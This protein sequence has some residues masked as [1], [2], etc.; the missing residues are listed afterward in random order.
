MLDNYGYNHTLRTFNT[1]CCSTVTIVTRRSV[2]VTLY[3]PCPSLLIFCLY[4]FLG[5]P[6]NGFP[7]VLP[8]NNCGPY[9]YVS[10]VLHSPPASY[11]LISPLYYYLVRRTNYEAPHYAVFSSFLLLPASYVQMPSSAPC[12]QKPS[13]FVLPLL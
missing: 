2:S 10:H 4:G 3:V 13:V 6:S 7:S 9:F 5:F 8:T 12:S 11:S 1:Y